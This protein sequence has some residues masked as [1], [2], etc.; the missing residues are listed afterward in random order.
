MTRPVSGGTSA[1]RLPALAVIFGLTTKGTLI[2]TPGFRSRKWQAHVLE[3]EHGLRAFAAQVLNRVLIADV[4]RTLYGV[5]HVPAPIIVGV[6]A[7]NRAGDATLGRNG[8]RS[9]GKYL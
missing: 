1:G 2:D 7:G 4:I 3:F 6:I 8:V 5:V 9:R